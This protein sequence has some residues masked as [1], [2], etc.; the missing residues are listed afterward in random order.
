MTDQAQR[1]K[2]AFLSLLP[3]DGATKGNGAL[4]RELDEQL[5]HDGIFVTEE[6]YWQVHSELV[7]AGVV[8]TGKGRGGSVRLIDAKPESF[9]LAT[10]VVGEEQP[11]EASKNKTTVAAKP[12]SARAKPGE[13]TQVLSYRHQDK[14]KNNPEVGMVT[15]ATDPDAGKTRWSYDPHIDPTLNFDPQRARTEKLIDDALDSGDVQQMRQAL[16]ELKRAQSPYLNWAG[17]A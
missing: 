8:A 3:A 5:V 11:S 1:I 17:K 12:V 15:P 7:E 16:E 6:Q 2:A 10:Q 4:R 14:R 9:D 13:E